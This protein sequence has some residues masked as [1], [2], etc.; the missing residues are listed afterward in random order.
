MKFLLRFC[1]VF[2]IIVGLIAVLFCVGLSMLAI[3]L[4]GGLSLDSLIQ[5]S[6]MMGPMGIAGILYV[7]SGVV[8]W[9]SLPSV[10]KNAVILS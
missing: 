7:W 6:L 1:S 3:G 9:E 5:A 10:R 4:G 8:L 2:N